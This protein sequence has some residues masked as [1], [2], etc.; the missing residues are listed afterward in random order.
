MSTI[1]VT[2]GI[3]K[4]SLMLIP[5]LPS[6]FIPSL[7]MPVFLTIAFAGAFAGLVLLP[8]HPADKMIDWVVPMSIVQGA[9][10]AG[11]TTGMGVAR[12]FGIGFYDRL[13]LTPAPRTA[14]LAGPLLASMLRSLFPYVLLVLIAILGGASFHDPVPG[15]V[16]LL[17]ASVG[18]A[19][20]A[21]MWSLGLA[22]RFKSMQVAPLMQ[23]G[24]FL[25][26]FLSTAQM[27]LH[28]LTGWLHD[29]AR[30]NPMTDV[31]ALARQG[32]LRGGVTWD[33]TYPGLVALL[34]MALVLGLFAHRGM[35]KVI[36]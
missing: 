11:I 16:M 9:A 10:F 7:V 1:A 13:L 27:P 2:W 34:G 35:R 17:V 6:T 23:M 8:G 4:R 18:T 25:T 26:I 36:P 5:R 22:L 29:V 12:D 3:A 15:A 30:V 14:L 31:L 21:G 19:L 20:V 32:F 33:S 28:L 24:L